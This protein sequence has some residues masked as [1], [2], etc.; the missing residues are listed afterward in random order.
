[1]VDN[2]RRISI[3]INGIFFFLEC[4]FIEEIRESGE[5][6][7]VV[8]HK[9]RILTDRHY[10]STRGARI[11]FSRLYKNQVWREGVRPEWSHF[12]PPDNKWLSNK[13]QGI[14]EDREMSESFL[15][16]R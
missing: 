16:A 6:R 1:M 7:L 9:G 13:R 10:D 4:V 3:L 12:Y 11:A 8:S 14:L 5:Y 2:N 15:P